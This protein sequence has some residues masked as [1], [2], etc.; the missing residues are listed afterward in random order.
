MCKSTAIF[1]SYMFRFFS[2]HTYQWRTGAM[3]FL[4]VAMT[5]PYVSCACTERCSY[6][7]CACRNSTYKVVPSP[8][9]KQVHH[10]SCALS[11]GLLSFFCPCYVFGKNAEAM[12]HDCC[13]YGFLCDCNELRVY[14]R[15]EIRDE[16]GIGVSFVKKF[17]TI[18]YK[19]PGYVLPFH[20]TYCI[21]QR[22]QY[23]RCIVA[24]K[25]SYDVQL[26]LRTTLAVVQHLPI[27]NIC[28]CFSAS[29]HDTSCL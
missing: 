24:V 28:R 7:F 18:Y 13:L 5:P 16:K 1:L 14:V 29:Q 3:E 27:Y 4:T 25:L 15:G 12:G 17:I 23:T 2:T 22:V 19:I 8:C 20:H 10:Y 21:T 6:T 26:Q 11:A 9:T